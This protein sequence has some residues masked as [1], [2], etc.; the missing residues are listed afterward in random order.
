MVI[1]D[2]KRYKRIILLIS[3]I[4]SQSF[5]TGPIQH[6]D[7]PCGLI[8]FRH[9]WNV[10]GTFNITDKTDFSN[11]FTVNAGGILVNI[12]LRMPYMGYY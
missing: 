11:Q 3:D 9:Y 7:S 1:D 12:L 5:T 8:E 2:Y 4:S 10:T 6:D